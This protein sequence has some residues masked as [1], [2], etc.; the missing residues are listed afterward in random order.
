MRARGRGLLAR[1]RRADHR[2]AR[3]RSCV[4][5]ARLLGSARTAWCSPARARA[6]VA[7]RRQ[8]ARLHQPRARAAASRARPVSGYGCLTGQGNGQGGREHGQKADQLPATGSIDDPAARRA[9]RRASGASTRTSLPGAGQVGVRAAR[10]ARPAGR[11]PRAARAWARTR[12]SRRPTRTHVE[13]AA[14]RRSTSS[15]VC[16]FF[17]SETAALADVVLPVAQWAEEDGTMT[18]LEGRVIRRRRARRA[19]RRRARPTS[20]CSSASP[21]GSGKREHFSLRQR[22]E[23]CS[24]SCARATAGGAGRLLRHHLRADRRA[25]RA[26]SGPAR[27]PS[28]PARRGCSPD[29]LR[30]ADGRARF[31]AVAHQ[32]PGRG[33]RRRVPALPHDRPRAGALPVGHAD[34]P[35]RRR[36]TR[37]PA[38]PVAE[39]HPQTA[40]RLGIA[41]GDRVSVDD[42]PRRARPFTAKVT[43]GIRATRCSC[44]STGAASRRPTG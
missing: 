28:I 2:R 7:G 18:N 17:L 39:M 11:R 23:T 41:D 30:D 27:R 24:T 40:Q 13:R 21:S 5:A 9:R 38:A 14:A 29:A 43:R 31:H 35:R 12:S 15:S 33:A 25:S 19:A 26:S 20:R 32:P 4:Q 16:D 34:A 6:A 37:W 3:A 42:A 22:R 36:S 44:R 8:R 10:R 1:A